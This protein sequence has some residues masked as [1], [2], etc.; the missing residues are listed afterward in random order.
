[1]HLV[2]VLPA[3]PAGAGEAE[4]QLGLRDDNPLVDSQHR[5]PRHGLAA[6]FTTTDAGAERIDQSRPFCFAAP[7]RTTEAGPGLAP[8]GTGSDTLSVVTDP[9]ALTDTTSGRVANPS[10]LSATSS[11]KPGALVSVTVAPS[12]LPAIA[13]G[14]SSF[15]ARANGG[16]SSTAKVSCVS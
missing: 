1:R 16:R 13:S 4:R 6:A 12:G 2:D 3:R 14:A 15:S 9:V 11:P 7:T 8:A 5:R 10:T